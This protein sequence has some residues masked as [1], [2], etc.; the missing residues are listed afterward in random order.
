MESRTVDLACKINPNICL[1]YCPL[2][3]NETNFSFPPIG[4][5]KLNGTEASTH[6]TYW[7]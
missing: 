3:Q 5:F 6:S 7:R 2:A 1:L 4:Y